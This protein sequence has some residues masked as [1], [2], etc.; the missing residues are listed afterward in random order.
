[1]INQES[2]RGRLGSKVKDCCGCPCKFVCEKII[3]LP[4]FKLEFAV[5]AGRNEVTLW[6]T[7]GNWSCTSR[8]ALN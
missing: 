1:M 6:Q 7:H 5:V 2:G 4:F 3:E 8:D